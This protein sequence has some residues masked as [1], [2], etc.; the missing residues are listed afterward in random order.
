MRDW[1]ASVGSL[2]CKSLG[3]IN[4]GLQC[5]TK[6]RQD[7]VVCIAAHTEVLSNAPDGVGAGP[8]AEID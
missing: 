3:S 6:F 7:F 2:D 4:M 8:S 1:I 5:G